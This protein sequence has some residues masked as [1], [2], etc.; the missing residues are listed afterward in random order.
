MNNASLVERW[1]AI[2]EVIR[3]YQ[4]AHDHRDTDR[5]LSTFT[6]NA[7]VHD[8]G[9][10]HRGHD[11]IRTWLSSLSTAFTY[12]RT[13]TDVTAVD[14][15]AWVLVNH[16]EG[17]FPGGEVDLRYRFRLSQGHIAELRIVP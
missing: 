6:S 16:L 5:A 1:A 13:L 14:G 3:S 17:D 15:D 2:P 4:E 12:T 8:D 10:E 9:R 11:E 7:V